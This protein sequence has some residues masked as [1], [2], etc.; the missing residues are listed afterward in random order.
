M[1]VVAAID[2][3][4]IKTGIS[5]GDDTLKIA[6]PYEVWP[7]SKLMENILELI[8]SRK[9]ELLVVG[10]ALNSDGTESKMSNKARN[11]VRKLR[12]RVDIKTVFVDEFGST[13]ESMSVSV[14][15]NKNLVDKLDAYSATVILNRYFSSVGIIKSEK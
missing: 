14:D 7:T 3:G 4:T 12:K 10:L 1:T 6:H 9:I 15:R 2:L 5:I 8:K 11:F 13:D